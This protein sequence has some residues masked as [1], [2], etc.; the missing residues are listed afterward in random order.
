MKIA[1]LQVAGPREESPSARRSRVG[2]MPTAARGADLVVPPE[3]WAVGYF[4]FDAYAEQAETL[5]GPT[6]TTARGR[7]REL[8][9]HVHLGNHARPRESTVQPYLGQ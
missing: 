3:P 5:D 8:D 7:A 4:A 9:A 2:R 6:V 1:T